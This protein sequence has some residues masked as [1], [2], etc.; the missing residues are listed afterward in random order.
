MSF[1]PE[2]FDPRSPVSHALDL[3]EVDT[4]DGETTRFLLGTD[5]VFV[6]MLGREWM[7]SSMASVT[8]MQSAIDGI[9]PVGTASLSYFQDPADTDLIAKLKSLGLSYIAGREIRFYIQPIALVE[10]LYRPTTAPI[11]WATRI[12]RQISYKANGAQDRQI[13]VSFET[14]AERRGA[15]RR[16]KM[17]TE[18]HAALLGAPNP[19]LEFKPTVDFTEEKLFG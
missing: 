4:S 13:S 12:M 9:A 19:S 16:I 8:G 15:A 5:G 1:F 18:G 14:W 6:D 17:D 2:G 3:V 7:G 10:D 11:L